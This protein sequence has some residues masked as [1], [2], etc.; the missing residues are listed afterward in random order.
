MDN[1]NLQLVQRFMQLPLAQRALFLEKLASKNLSLAQLPIPAM[2]ET[3]DALPLSYAQQRQWFLW[4]WEP[5]AALY[6]IPLAL[7]LK[8]ALDVPALQRSFGALVA[9]HES[10]RTTFRGDAEQPQQVIHAELAVPLQVEPGNAD[11][12][13]E[14]VTAEAMRPFDLEQGPLLRVKLL[15][16]A[17]QEH[18]LVFTVH[19]IVADGW[20]LPLMVDELV[21]L[22]AGFCRGEPAQL[23]ALP[24]QY[25]DYALWQRSWMEAGERERQLAY[26][27]D[28]LGDEQPLLELPADRPRPAVSSHAGARLPIELDAPLVAAIK[29]VAQGQGT[30]PFVVLLASFQA[31]LHRYSGQADIRIGVPVANRNRVETERLIGFFVNTQVLRAQFDGELS[32][33]ALLE[34]VKRRALGAQAHQDLPFEQLVD[35]LQPERSLSHS[36]L[37]QV[38]YNHQTQARGTRQ[39]VGGLQVEEMLWANDSAKFDL[40]LDTFEH[41]GGISAALTYATELFDEGTVAQMGRH[42]LNLLQ[43]AVRHPQRPIAELALLDAPERQRLLHEWN[44]TAAPYPDHA[45]LHQLFETQ[46]AATPDAPALLF[47]DTTLSYAELNRQANALAHKLRELGVGP[48]VLVGIAMARGLEMVVGLLAILKAG[49]AYVPLDPDYPQARLEYMLEDSQARVLLSQS[50]LLERLPQAS[51]ARTLLLDTLD[52]SAYPTSNPTCHGAPENLAY[53]IYTSGSTGLPKGVLIEHRNA[54]ALVGWAQSVYSREQLCGVLA[55]TSICFDLSVWELFVTLASGGYAVI[56]RNALELPHLPAKDQ[57]RLVNTVPSAIQALLESG[58]LP[59]SVRTVNLAGEALKQ[60]L[61]DALYETGHIEQVYDLYG[62]SEDTTYSTYT[63]RQAGGTASIGRPISNSAAYILGSAGQVLPVGGAGELYM[64]GAGL[65]RGYLGRPGLTAERFVPNP[66]DESGGRF[67]RTGDLARYQADGQIQYAGRLD[68]QVKVRGFRIELGEIEARLQAQPQVSQVALLALDGPSGQQLVAYI[69]PTELSLVGRADDEAALRSELRDALRAQLPDYMVPAHLLLLDRLPLTPN[70]K[71]D[72][73]ALPQPD[74]QVTGNAYVAPHSELERQIAAIWAEV[75]KRE[76]IGLTDNFFELGGDSIVSLQVVSRARQQDIQFTP[77]ELFQHQTVQGLAAVARRHGGN[78]I[79]QGKAQGSTPLVPIQHW[80]FEQAID[81]RQHWNQAVLLAPNRSLSAEPLAAALQALLEHHD[82][83]R[84]RFA[85]VDGAWQ[86][87]FAEPSTEVLWVR[88]VTDLDALHAVAEQAQASLDLAHGPLLRAV[89]ATL[90]DGNQRLLLVIHH[91]VVDGVSWRV[92]LEDLQRAYQALATGQALALP[93]KTSS[94][95][96]WAE[97]LAEYAQG[98]ELHQEL[99]YWHAQLHGVDAG[100]PCDRPGGAN[101]ERH[102]VSVSTR[103]DAQWTRQLLQEAPAAYRTQINDLLLTALARVIG[104]WTGQADVLVRL[105]GHGREDLFDGLDLTRTVG[106]FTSLYPLKLSTQPTLAASIKSVKEQLRGVPNKGLGYGLLRYLGDAPARAALAQLPA[107]E[108]VFNY[109]GQFDA[110]FDAQDGLF[111]PAQEGSGAARS[112]D[113]PLGSL[114]ALNGQ[115]YGGELKLAWS[116]SGEVFD[117][118]TIQGLADAYAEELKALIAHCCDGEQHGATPSDFPLAGLSQ[119]QVDALPVAVAQIADVYPLSPMQQ[120]MLFHTQ[121]EQGS[122][123]YINQMRVDVEGLDGARFLRAWREAQQAH[124]ILR[125]SFVWDGEFERPL[126]IVHR[127]VEAGWRE[128]DLRDDAALLPALDRLADAERA[129]GFDQGQAPLMRLT[130]VRTGTDSHQLIFTHHHILMDGWSTS[131]LLGEVLQRYAGQPVAGQAGLYRDY[132][133]WLQ[134]Q[135]PA[136]AQAFWA[137]QLAELEEPTLLLHALGQTQAPGQAGQGEHHQPFDRARTQRLEAFA[138]S[139]RV[140]VN[141]VMQAAWLLLLQRYT[142]HATVCFGATVAGRPAELAHV[143]EQIGLFINTLPVVGSPRLTQTVGEWLSEVQRINLGLRE[144]EHT[145]L[146]DVQRLAG[147]GGQALF[148]SLMVFENYPVSEALQKGAPSGLRFGPVGNREQTNY[149]LTLLV[150][151]GATLSV[152]FNYDTCRW[153]EPAVERLALH[154]TTLLDAIVA[155]PGTRVSELPMLGAQEQQRQLI[156]WNATTA[157]FPRDRSVQQLIEA[158]VRATPEATALVFADQHLSYAEVN[159][160]AN[161]LARQ[162]RAQGV[163]A[164]SL[165]GIAMERSLEMVIGLLGVLKA[166]GAYVPFDPEYPRDRL[167]YMFEDSGVRLLLSQPHLVEQ[168]PVP[169][170]VEVIA[171]NPGADLEGDWADDDLHVDVAPHNLAYVIYTSGSTGRPKGAGNSQQALVNRLCWM[172]RAYG[173]QDTDSVLQKTPFSFDVSVWEFFW[174]LMT[175][176]RLVVAQPG[177]HRDPELLVR[178]LCDHAITTVHFVPSMLQAFLGSEQVEQ[179]SRLRRVMCSGEALPAELARQTLQRLPQAG[180]YNLYG[181]TEAAIDVTHWTCGAD[182]GIAVPI[183]VPIDNLKTHILEHSL[184]PAVCGGV[185]ELYLGGVGLAR[186]YH[187]RPALT[188]ERFVPDPFD[189]KGGRLYR[190]GDLARY[191]A[192]GV[193]DYVGRID[194]QVKIRGLRIELGE[195]EARLLEQAAVRE[196]VV[197]AVDAAHGKQLVA[198]VVPSEADVLS[199]LDAQAHWRERLRAALK[200]HLPDYMVPTHLLALAHLPLTPNG[201]LDRKALPAP[202]AS[203]LQGEYVEPQTE[204]EQRIAEVWAQVLKVERVGLDDNFFELGGDSIVS[205]QVVSRARKLGIH[206]TPKQL[207]KHQTVRTLAS[208]ASRI[209]SN[210]IDQGPVVG[211]LPLTPIQQWFFEQD[212]PVRQHWN[213]AVLLTTREVLEAQPLREA[214]TV[215]LAHHDALRLRFTA[216][217]KTWQALF[218]DSSQDLLWERDVANGTALTVLVDHAQRSLDLENG[219]LLRALLATM[220]DGS[221]RLL[222]VIHHLVVDGVSWRIL[223]EDLQQAYQACLTR[224]PLV[225]PAKT[226]AFKTWAEHLQ[227]YARSPELH[228]QLDYWQMQLQGVPDTLP[229]DHSAGGNLVRHASSVSTRL[230]AQWTRQLLHDAPAAYR[231]QINDLL[232]TALARVLSR[233]TGQPEVLVRLEGHGREDLFS[234]LD[235]SRTLGWFTSLF[236]V[237]LSPQAGLADSL[238]TIKEQLRAVP[239][240]GVGYGVLRYLADARTGEALHALPQGQ[241]LFNYLGQLDGNFDADDSLF[242]PAQESPG[243]VYDSSSAMGAELS[244]NSQVYGGELRLSWSFSRERFE[245]ATVQRLADEYVQELQAL[246]EHCSNGTAQGLTPSDFPLAGLD[247]AQLDGLPMAAGDIADV[248]P[249][250]PMQ[251]GMLFHTLYEQGRGDYINQLRVDVEGLDSERFVAAWQAA[252]RA[253]DILRTGFVWQDDLGQAVQ[254]VRREVELPVALYDWRDSEDR[255]DATQALAQAERD[256]GFEL[257]QAPLLRLA[258]IRTD[259]HRHHV[260]LTH[261]HLLLD[262]WSTS[263]LLGE[264]LQ[265]YAA[266]PVRAQATRYRDYI[267]WLQSQNGKT[268]QAFWQNQ[269]ASLQEPTR[270]AQAMGASRR[271]HA[272]AQGEHIQRFDVEQTDCLSRFARLNRVTVNTLVQAVWLLLLQ[273]YTGQASVCFGAT[274]AGRPPQLPG[275]EEQI[276]LFINTLPVI[277]AP[278]AEQ[279]VVQWIRHVQANNLEL[280]EFEHTPLYEVQRWAGMG[281]EALFD[282]LLVFENYPADEALSKGAQGG[283]IFGA[284]ATTEQ[285]NY[286][287]TVEVSLGDTL[288]VH[289]SH[290]LS[291]LSGE[292]VCQISDSFA[293]LLQALVSD[294]DAALGTLPLLAP[295]VQQTLLLD[296]NPSTAPADTGLRA[297]Q[298][299]QAQAALRP[300]AVALLFDDQQ[301]TYAELDQRSNR[302]AHALRA[303]GVGSDALVGIAAERGLVLAV[304]LLGI[305]K[306]GGAYVP[307]DPAFPQDRLAYMMADSGMSLLLG[308]ATSLARL[309]VPAGLPRVTLQADDQW[310]AEQPCTALAE[311]ATADSLAYVIYTSGSTGLPKGVAIAHHA[312]SVFCEVAGDYS[313]LCPQDRVLQFATVSFDGFVEQFFPPLA[314]GACVVMRDQLWDPDRFFAEVRR[315]GITLADLPAAYWRLLALER[316]PA[317]DYA[318]LKQIHVGGEAVAPDAMQAWLENGPAAV[319]LVNTYGPTEATVVA[320]TFA[321]SRLDQVPESGVP[322]GRA[323]PGRTMYALDGGLMPTPVGVAGELFIGGSGCLARGYHQRPSLTAERFVPDPFDLAGG[324]RLY[325][326]GDL[327]YFDAAGEIAYRGRADH[328]VKVRGFRI[329]LG[330][331]EQHLQAHPL[332]REAA[333]LAV[334][335]AGGKQLC[336]YVVGHAPVPDDVREQIKT[337]LVAHLPDYMVPSVLVV[338]ERMPLTP[339]GKLDRKALP[340]AD[341]TQAQHTYVA[342]HSPLEQQLADIWAGVLKLEQVGVTDN[343][344]ELGG[345]SIISLQVVSR[346][347]KVGIHLT[348]KQLFE[349]QTVQALAAVAGETQASYVDQGP[350]TGSM[351]LTPIQRWFFEEAIP[352]R[353]HWNQ[354]VLLKA[355][356]PV[357]VQALQESLDALV[358]HHDALRLRFTHRDPGWHAEFQPTAQTTLWQY[359]VDGASELQSIA[360][361]AQRSLDLAQGD[362]LRAVLFDLS[363]GSQRLL[364]IVHHLVVDGVSWR[365]LLEDLQQAYY[366][367]VAHQPVALPEKTSSFKQW[368]EQLSAYA[369][370]AELQRTLAYWQTQLQGVSDQLPCDHPDGDNVLRCAVSVRT[371]L[372]AQ[373]TRKLLQE[374]PAAYRTQIND[375]LLTALARVIARWTGRDD[376][377]IR[378]EGHGREDLFEGLDLSRTVGWFTSLYPVRLNVGAGLGEALKTVKEQLREIPGKGLGYG[379]LRYLGDAQTR[380][381]LQQLPQGEI[382][383]NY[384]G[385]FD[386]SFDAADTLFVPAAESSGASLDGESPLGSLLTINGQVYGGELQLEWSFSQACFEISTVR[387]L[388]D[389]LGDELKALV[390]HCCEPGNGGFTPSDFPLARLSQRQ[391]DGLVVPAVQLADAYPLSPM[392]Q[393]MLFHALQDGQEGAY[394]TQSA[395]EVQGLH[396]ERF[397]EAWQHVVDRHDILRS[398]FISSAQLSDPLQ[399]VYRHVTLPVRIHDWRGQAVSQ[400]MLKTLETQDAA[401]GFALDTAPLMRLTLVRMDDQRAHLIWTSHHILMDG[402]SSSQLLAE[403]L[404]TYH[405][406]PSTGPVRRYRDY[407]RWLAEQPQ[408]HLERFWSDKLRTLESATLLAGSIAPQADAS[409]VGHDALYLKWDAARTRDLREQAQRLRVTPNTLIQ[410]A[411]LLLLQRYTGQATVCFGATVAGRPASLAGADEMLGLFINTLPVVQTPQPQQRVSDWLQALQGYN[412]EL[413]DHEHAALADVQRWAGR[414]GQALFDSIVVFENFP[415][416]ERLQ[417]GGGGTLRFGEVSSR[418]VT[419]YA[420]DLAVH[421]TDTFSVEFLY[422]RG[423]FT[424]AAAELLRGSFERLL[425][426]LLEH[427]DATLGSLDMLTADQAEAAR[428]G[429]LL[430]ASEATLP[431]LAARIAEHAQARPQ[432]VAVVCAEQRLTYAELDQRANRL[433]HLLLAQGVRPETTVGIALARSVEVIVA[434]LAVMKTG[435]AYVPLDIDYPPERLAWIVEDSAMH[436]LITSSDL[437]PRFAQ[438]QRCVALDQQTLHDLPTS[439]PLVQVEPDNLAYLIYTSGS[440]GKP[441]GVAVSHG[442]IRMHCQ[443]IA[444]LYEMDQR[445]RELLFMSFAFDGAQERWLSTL[446]SGGCL[447][448]RDNRLWSAEETFDVLHAQRIDIA[449]FPPAYLQQLAEYAESQSRPAP[450]V[451]IY[452]FGGDAVADALFEQVKRSLRPQALTNGYGPT[453]TVVTPL[454]WKVCAEQRCEAVYAP[455][456]RRVGERTLHVLDADLN[457]LPDGVAGELYI[458]GEGVARGYH[459]RPGL[460]AERFVADPFA[461]GAR[462]YR[463]GDRVRRRADGV[464]DFIGRLDNQLKIR[465]FRIEPGEIEARLRNLGDVRDAVV[466]A[467]EIGT[468]KQLLGYVVTGNPATSAERLREALRAELPDYMVPA[469]LVLLPA[470]PLT[471]NGKVDRQALPAPDFAG[472]RQLVAPRNAIERALTKIWQEVLEVPSVGVDDNF[473]ELGGDSLR[474]LKMLSKVRADEQLPIELKLRDVIARPTIGE[475]SGYSEASEALDPLLPLNSR[476]AGVTPLFCLHAGF[477]TVFDYEPLARRLEGRCTVYGLQCRMLLDHA[478]EDDSIQSMAIDYA[479]YIRQKQPDGP[480]Q[481][482]GW[483]LGGTLAVLVAQEL[484]SQGQQVTLL[485]LV[486]SFVPDASAAEAVEETWDADLGGF[487]GVLLGTP[488]DVPAL[489]AGSSQAVLEA[490][491]EQVRNDQA[492]QSSYAGIS[493]AELAHTFIVAMRLKTLSRGMA[494][495]PRTQ[496]RATCWWAGSEVDAAAIPGSGAHVAVA[497]GHYDILRQPEVLEGLIGGLRLREYAGE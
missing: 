339:S 348:P 63:L 279:T 171:L 346:A 219:P 351:P 310:L 241:V 138:R 96:V 268:T 360:E 103:L 374:A 378:L 483:S 135:D 237:K 407:I 409:R 440:T 303:Q 350:V 51:H 270:L 199:S 272:C 290:D 243:Q 149:P 168:L 122:G 46:A 100:L 341:F 305:H 163:G 105:E 312:L 371:S 405:G 445:T 399:V 472:Q 161:R 181:P 451:R 164:E 250:S 420:M 114:L 93:G 482:A 329:E 201:K 117:T 485:G 192:D 119:A 468:G 497:A 296:W 400:S 31:L 361:R 434:F 238:K 125:S 106:W 29:A 395:V 54:C 25:A 273:R 128:L 353:Q 478:W 218:V 375:L 13:L 367:R 448:V 408:A 80:F 386:A 245:P 230:D 73:K 359:D 335:Q 224:Q 208:I 67:Y 421:L 10:L 287:L 166:G 251:Q 118:A 23:P 121:Y 193:I 379:V 151:T 413:R 340:A 477:G 458:G 183:G 5:Q 246:I 4:Q 229:C 44:D 88:E 479:Q 365:V 209:G 136:A 223:L 423:S 410:A 74:T 173:L 16:L 469:Q 86:A 284:V 289:Y 426:A 65:A 276:G 247:Q 120:G 495:L 175:G 61:V 8:G 397:V 297:H 326:T 325:R 215:L 15:R 354:A 328:Q 331:I 56:A 248:Y 431:L 267:A 111:A 342:P 382:V 190:T 254:V 180:L 457:P 388:A 235:L 436:L 464:I 265:R 240:K 198:Y 113:A 33:S 425:L 43:D 356:E 211:S 83:L 191:R 64:A 12:L 107:G 195:I 261:H 280:R 92:L 253:H 144:F 396:L 344:F 430:R 377:L 36:P 9:R 185:G 52:L 419:N 392:Q 412:L 41:E 486:D 302:L 132:I 319:Q 155:S 17:E 333:V 358:S 271:L 415:V 484:E 109:L 174:P 58:G 188:A 170:S 89:L 428:Q 227:H 90:G 299:F 475:L 39:R 492:G 439:A 463:T 480:Y 384:L 11:A 242:I 402:W 403:V 318:S 154:L 473:F 292:A 308:D 259:A 422:L 474:V 293:M 452:C 429:N 234:E 216:Q 82:A 147:Q 38:M 494:P 116:F 197:L 263:R 32:F 281:N 406:H 189:A 152:Q 401:E 435:A 26:W 443:A 390:A 385:Q 283:L 471:P 167:V 21:Q 28:E 214:L 34:Q 364:L 372:D 98:A 314:R 137:Q 130:L 433:A 393:G 57:V 363:D 95:K 257:S 404:Q 232:L 6:N 184:Q 233:W 99:D 389:A 156:D 324:G 465:G 380:H 416:D 142:G 417:E 260:I 239:D 146:N 78:A 366:A 47:A 182:D 301:L 316:R 59:T 165:V 355:R 449:C 123:D 134:R 76:Q 129:R 187:Q 53:S 153:P 22:Y 282:S 24:I 337:Y 320:T 204:L 295:A 104:R 27:T 206:I 450:P 446:S 453:E 278:R 345:D 369:S 460:T 79:D 394:I 306:A 249:L 311:V 459:Q 225:L 200:E 217:S 110:S 334:D 427:S 30:T 470:L 347:R 454:L 69:V 343:F 115:V 85:A 178:T 322:I 228:A 20:S 447:V 256:R 84:L 467:R 203:A 40:T 101:L 210:H 294:A 269:L 66:F 70:G 159:R 304:A 72:R 236:P 49:G 291:L 68:H 75:L 438:V 496:V 45:C 19:H 315:H 414:P 432:A 381:A 489:A 490:V 424:A 1:R 277:G 266:N 387:Q 487:L 493:T 50:S 288:K 55:A 186:G 150:G 262:G 133:G 391:L 357:K 286:P 97:R 313:R 112:P 252:I 222:L 476:V 244:I 124:D 226:S 309:P 108:I 441:K 370:D 139:Q 140:T 48:D 3:V 376:V 298:L 176:A 127:Q 71:L 274:V 177:A 179:C 14:Q 442:Q 207:F 336:G 91:L 362:V 481:L 42:W 157:D 466:V 275:V 231:T 194:H 332:V 35:A 300:T 258:L 145:P 491:I 255:I 213:Q 264:V 202:D 94:V 444:G 327:G 455:I 373:W 462:L 196:A 221:Q 172:Q 488:V 383:F 220:A 131:R 411:W 148:D 141:T 368:A 37:F 321:C 102:A 162:L 418:D 338:L 60:S 169:T 18:V 160:R 158:Q 285:T 7:T 126:Q 398:G 62:P 317:Q 81:A 143:E 212:I 456:G 330:E 352:V 461:Q 205:L 77:K 307:L 2:R 349:H 323:I 87:E 437:Q